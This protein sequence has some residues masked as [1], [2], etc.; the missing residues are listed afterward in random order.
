MYTRVC[1]LPGEGIWKL[2]SGP[3]LQTEL[4]STLAVLAGKQ[5]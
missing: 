2:A 1:T 4:G 5:R 3:K